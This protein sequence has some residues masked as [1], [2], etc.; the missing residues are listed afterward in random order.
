[1]SFWK[2]RRV[3]VT[4]GSGF[5][6]SHLVEMLL[7]AGARVT[8]TG[9]RADPPFLLGVL[10]QIR[11][12]VGDLEDRRFCRSALEEQDVVMHLAAQVGGVEYNQ[13]HHASLFIDNMAPFLSLLDAAREVQVE[14]MLV[15]SSACVY[16]RDPTI[17]IPEEEGRSGEPEPTNSGY[18][19]AKRMQEYLGA[20]FAAQFG[21]PVAIARP[22]NAYGPRDDF[23]PATSH[24]IPALIRRVLADE[25]PLTVWGSGNQTRGFLFVRDFCEGL[26]RTAEQYPEA[27]PL[28]IG[29]DEETSIRGLVELI[30]SITGK[31]PEVRYDPSRPEGQPRRCC[32]TRKMER[33]LGW[34]PAT[35]LAEGLRQTIQ[36]Y[37]DRPH[38]PSCA[39]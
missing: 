2:S 16:P 14:R 38:D 21:L 30:L 1:M 10:P 24:V 9:R 36:W 6:G 22:F 19:W 11:F 35:P 20:A 31:H 29:A 7:A 4:G 37:R 5:V 12:L 39:A 17:P 32:D 3:L 8:A 34:K 28:N 33:V 26:M 18:G 27:D 23:S 13:A 15:T 25:D